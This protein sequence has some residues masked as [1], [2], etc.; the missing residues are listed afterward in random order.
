MGARAGG[1]RTG[2][3]AGA[4]DGGRSTGRRRPANGAAAAAGARAWRWPEHEL[5]AVV[6]GARAWRRHERGGGGRSTGVAVAGARARGGGAAAAGARAVGA[7]GTAIGRDG[8]ERGGDGG[9]AE[10]VALGIEQSLSWSQA[11]HGRTND[12]LGQRSGVRDEESRSQGVAAMG[13]APAGL[14]DWRRAG[15]RAPWLGRAGG[16]S[17][18]GAVG[19]VVETDLGRGSDHGRRGGSGWAAPAGKE[20]S[21]VATASRGK[22]TT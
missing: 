14:G 22:K 5:G 11:R 7:G 10:R 8:D 4:R 2:P 16:H 12:H 9:G 13:E 18:Q 19:G 3:L 1:G 21:S 6:A 17:A 15:W 20:G